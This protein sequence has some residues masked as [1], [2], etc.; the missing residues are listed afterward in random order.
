VSWSADI[1]E[2]NLLPWKTKKHV[3]KYV[4]NK[5]APTAGVQVSA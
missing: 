5:K 2:K 1:P 4:S 3:S